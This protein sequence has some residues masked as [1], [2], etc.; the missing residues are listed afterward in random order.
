ML[1][2]EDG[3][4]VENAEAFADVATADAYAAARAINVWIDETDV[5]KK[6][7]A[8]RKA[9]DYLAD[10]YVNR[11]RGSPNEDTQ[12]L[13]FPRDGGDFI[14]NAIIRANIE[15]AIIALNEPLF[16][17]EDARG[18]VLEE[19][20]GVGP[21]SRSAKY[22][23]DGNKQRVFRQVEKMLKNLLDYDFIRVV[24]I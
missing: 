13:P 7:A 22:S 10:N 23:N 18:V 6:E 3:S 11:W 1:I 9:A 19:A 17:V 4:V 2:I 21:L 8:L 16:T 15:L 12:A 14:P 5:T 20:R 24:R